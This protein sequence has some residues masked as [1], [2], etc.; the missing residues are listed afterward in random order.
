MINLTRDQITSLY[1][2][3]GDVLTNGVQGAKDAEHILDKL[4]AQGMSVTERGGKSMG[5]LLIMLMSLFGMG[6]PKKEN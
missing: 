6:I 5:A 1:T 3:F 4:A 2:T